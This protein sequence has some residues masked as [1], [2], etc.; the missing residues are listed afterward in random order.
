VLQY[1]FWIDEDDAGTGTFETGVDTLVRNWSENPILLQAPGDNTNYAADARCSALVTC[2]GTA[3]NTVA[4][5]CPSTSTV[6]VGTLTTDGSNAKNDFQWSGGVI[7]HAVAEGLLSTLSGAYATDFTAFG[8]LGSSHTLVGG[9]GHWLLVRSDTPSAGSFC[10]SPGP[11]PWDGGGA[12]GR[13][14]VLP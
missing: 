5:N 2:V 4:V 12:A 13:D 14:G 7:D 1:R 8:L 11:G 6:F 10:N 3:H 9:D